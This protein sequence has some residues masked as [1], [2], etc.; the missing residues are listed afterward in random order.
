MERFAGAMRRGQIKGD[1]GRGNGYRCLKR[2][3]PL[4]EPGTGQDD[5]PGAQDDMQ[6]LKPQFDVAL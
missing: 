3:S 2:V 5:G 4:R 6:R 1:G